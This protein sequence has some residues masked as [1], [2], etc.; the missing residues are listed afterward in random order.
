MSTISAVSVVLV[1]LCIGTFLI[2]TTHAES[3][4]VG[5]K[6]LHD[7]VR[8]KGGAPGNAGV[9]EEEISGVEAEDVLKKFVRA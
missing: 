3:Q 8:Q 4:S 1:V 5:V 6:W 9:Q 2:D 7:M